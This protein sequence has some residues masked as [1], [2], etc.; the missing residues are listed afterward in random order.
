MLRI[1]PIFLLLL[2]LPARAEV[3]K[4]MTD[5]PAVHSLVAQV[6]EGVDA[7]DILL[8]QGSDPHSF[9]LRPSQARALSQ[10]DL[11]FWIGPELTPWLGRAIKG[12]G[13]KGRSITL[14][15]HASKN[16]DPHAWLDPQNAALWLDVIALELAALDPDSAS[17][18]KANAAIARSEI[19]EMQAEVQR[20][21]APIH[22]TPIVVFHDAYGHFADRF[23]LN[24][25]GSIRLGDA[26]APG[27]A[28]LARLR[29]LISQHNIGCAFAEADH[30]PALVQSLLE[31]TDIP[32]GTLDP[33]GTTLDYGPDLYGDLIRNLATDIAQ[34]L[35]K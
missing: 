1:L 27:A 22:T 3:P 30:D 7:P 2:A 25:V 6:M 21:L 5:I 31:G 24:I 16:T 23:D 10:A 29:A 20:T 15:D 4:V 33:I 18:Y 11:V 8:T 35:G 26:A 9:Q 12:V 17:I 19:A 14:L 28:H 34:C 32:I 13:I